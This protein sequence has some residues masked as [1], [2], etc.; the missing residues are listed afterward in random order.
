[1]IPT[2]GSGRMSSIRTDGLYNGGNEQR[3]LPVGFGSTFGCT[4]TCLWRTIL[5]CTQTDRRNS[6]WLI[7]NGVCTPTCIRDEMVHSRFSRGRAPGVLLELDRD[8]RTGS[9]DGAEVGIAKKKQMDR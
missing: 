1:M 6:P 7:E 8:D 5:E 2:C 9:L 3:C 4:A